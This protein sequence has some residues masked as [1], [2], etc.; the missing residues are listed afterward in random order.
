MTEQ[1]LQKIEQ[2]VVSNAI[3]NLLGSYIEENQF[4]IDELIND[5]II[6]K[7]NDG[8]VNIDISFNEE[9]ESYEVYAF[10]LAN[11]S[12]IEQYNQRLHYLK[13]DGNISQQI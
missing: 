10:K 6:V 3:M 4:D 1:K 8:I 12:V 7:F 13:Y 9:D 11:G 5:I 2:L